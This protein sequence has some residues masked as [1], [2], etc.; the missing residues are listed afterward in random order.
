[1]MFA[2]V[3]AGIDQGVYTNAVLVPFSLGDT[4]EV[5]ITS[6][7]GETLIRRFNVDENTNAT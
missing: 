3:V 7:Q 2:N 6:P 4:V 1:M 5:V